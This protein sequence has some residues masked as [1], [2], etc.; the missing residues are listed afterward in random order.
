MQIKESESS[1]AKVIFERLKL[2]P[3]HQAIY[4]SIPNERPVKQLGRLKALGLTAGVSD[5][6]LIFKNLTLFIE[7]KSK[8]G[9]LRPSQI[10]FQQWCNL[11][12]K[13]GK[14]K[15]SYH[16][17]RSLDDLENLLKEYGEKLC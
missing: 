16:V 15:V 1:I 5:Y 10:E 9:R 6:V 4:F 3:K 8:K 11:A 7:V 14:L 17:V 13:I 2:I 12:S